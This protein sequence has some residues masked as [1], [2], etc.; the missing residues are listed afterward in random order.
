MVA[1]HGGDSV[2]VLADGK[3]VAFLRS[4]SP[5]QTDENPRA[6]FV[7]WLGSNVVKRITQ[8]GA[9]ADKIDCSPDGTRVAYSAPSFDVGASNVFTVHVDEPIA[10][11]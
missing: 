1:G 7:A 2:C 8:W 3:R 4:K 9:Y 10:F 5:D 6:V 11:S